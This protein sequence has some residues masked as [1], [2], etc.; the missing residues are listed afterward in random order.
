MDISA[1]GNNLDMV[2]LDIHQGIFLL[3]SILD[4]VFLDIQVDMFPQY[5]M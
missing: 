2:W 5:N 4:R 1:L 3:G